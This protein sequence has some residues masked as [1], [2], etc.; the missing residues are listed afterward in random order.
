MQRGTGIRRPAPERGPT[1]STSRPSQDGFHRSSA[2]RFLEEVAILSSRACL[3]EQTSRDL[4]AL[5][6]ANCSPVGGTPRKR[7]SDK[8]IRGAQDRRETRSMR[9]MLDLLLLLSILAGVICIY[10][11]CPGQQ[12]F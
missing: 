11:F 3:F 4:A 12:M 9:P 1:V 8:V 10:Q 7:R 2:L 6:G 5:I